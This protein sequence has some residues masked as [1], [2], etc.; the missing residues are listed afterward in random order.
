MG[1]YYVFCNGW[2]LVLQ[3][4]LLHTAHCGTYN[5]GVFAV[6][7]LNKNYFGNNI[8]HVFVVKTRVQSSHS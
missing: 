1:G 2:I 5:L 4:H 8:D 3:L 6:L 7:R